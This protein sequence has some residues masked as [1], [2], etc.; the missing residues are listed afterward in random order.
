MTAPASPAGRTL[1][2]EAFP[3]TPNPAPASDADRAALMDKPVFGKVFTDHMARATWTGGAWSDRGV[4]PLA[5]LPMHPGAAVLHY[6]QQVFEGLKAYRWEDGSIWAF[7]PDANAE[8]LQDSA[9]RLAIPWLPVDDFLASLAALVQADAAWVPDEDG[10]C[11]YLRP[12]LMAT[13]P[14]LLVQPADTYGY[15]VTASP[16]GAYMS[17]PDGVAIWV[18]RGYHRA[19]AGGTG[20]AKTAGNYAA[21]MLPQQQAKDNGCSQVLFLDARED[22]FVEELGG[23]NLM[24][25]FSDGS[26]AT[27]R[28]TGT[29]LPGITRDSIIALLREEGR[30]VRERD[31][32][33]SEIV[34]GLESGAITEMFACGTAAVVTPL[35]R[36]KS[37]D[38]DLPIG[39]G[40]PGPVA[41]GIKKQLTDIQYGRAED[42]F[43]WMVRL[44]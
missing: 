20:A 10:S 36:L 33:L 37:D 17:S 42:P 32:E 6:A 19:N 43:G 8:R 18:S 31:I 11:L 39:D 25:V 7:R 35:A 13:E 12:Y 14:S 34:S 16:V 40:Q 9:E 23:M 26:I 4:V 1:S 3:L 22:R 28:L 27:P 24:L 38:F 5:P 15:V 21:S 30:A 41:T 29:I 2:G 44:A